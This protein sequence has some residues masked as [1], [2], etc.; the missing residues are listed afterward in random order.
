MNP[1]RK[2][3]DPF[4]RL[5]LDTVLTS[6]IVLGTVCAGVWMAFRGPESVLF[7]WLLWVPVAALTVTAGE[8]VLRR[9]FWPQGQI[10]E[11]W[12]ERIKTICFP[13]L[14]ILAGYWM[15]FSG[16]YAAIAGATLYFVASQGVAS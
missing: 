11:A 1:S 2:R 6:V 3:F 16:L 9:R 5:F 4:S 12:S 7:G 8:L 13:G 14:G 15:V 10:P